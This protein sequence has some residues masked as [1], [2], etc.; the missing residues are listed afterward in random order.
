[1]DLIVSVESRV[2]QLICIRNHLLMECPTDGILKMEIDQ[3][4]AISL[5]PVYLVLKIVV[6]YLIISKPEY[7]IFHVQVFW[8][9][10]RTMEI[11]VL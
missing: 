6:Q 8:F 3:N 4:L 2:S 10:S 7:E 1:M 11:C 5:D 9:K